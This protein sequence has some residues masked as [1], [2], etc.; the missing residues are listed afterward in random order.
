MDRRGRDQFAIRFGTRSQ[1]LWNWP[2]R[3]E[4]EVAYQRDFWTD[5]FWEWSPM[6]NMMATTHRQ[7]VAVWGGPEFT[8]LQKFEHPGVQFIQFSPGENYLATMSVTETKRGN[9]LCLKVFNTRTAQL[10]RVFEGPQEEIVAPGQAPWPILHWS[11]GVEDEYV[12]KVAP[13]G[14]AIQVGRK[15]PCQW[16]SR[17]FWGYHL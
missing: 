4:A 6:G 15:W 11:G 14:D 5:F 16:G 9:R 10:L 1:V 3:K 12:A 17:S 13:S 8:R 7:G 2:Q